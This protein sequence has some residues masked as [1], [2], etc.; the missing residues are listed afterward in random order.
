[1]LARHWLSK[2]FNRLVWFRLWSTGCKGCHDGAAIDGATLR[3]KPY[4][5][6]AQW[7]I[8]ENGILTS[9]LG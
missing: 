9:R 2:T 1:M 3:Q 7:L 8:C 6:E 4:L 5:L